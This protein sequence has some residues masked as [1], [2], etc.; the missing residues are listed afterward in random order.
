MKGKFFR[1]FLWGI[2]IFLLFIFSDDKFSS[3]KRKRM[4]LKTVYYDFDPDE[5]QKELIDREIK[6]SRFVYNALLMIRCKKWKEEKKN[7]S[8]EDELDVLKKLIK[9]NGWLKNVEKSTLVQAIRD[10]DSDFYK[11]FKKDG[12]YP[13]CRRIMD[14]HQWYKTKNTNNSIRTHKHNIISLPKVDLIK[15]KTDD[16]IRGKI[17]Y[18]KISKFGEQYKASL[19]VEIQ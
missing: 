1:V 5:E 17:Q 13:K 6:A 10:L 4:Q 2:K 14:E 16:K 9:Q 7:L 15:L 3:V 11:F 18:A 12:K 8:F 19:T